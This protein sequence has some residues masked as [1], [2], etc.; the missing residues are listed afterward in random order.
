MP[1]GTPRKADQQ[2]GQRVAPYTPALDALELRSLRRPPRRDR[3]RD[4]R[5]RKGPVPRDTRPPAQRRRAVKRWHG[6]ARRWTV[7][8]E[9]PRRNRGMVRLALAG[10]SMRRIAGFGGA[11]G[12]SQVHRIVRQTCTYSGGRWKVSHASVYSMQTRGHRTVQPTVG[13]AWRG[14]WPAV[15][16][17]GATAKAGPKSPKVGTGLH[18]VE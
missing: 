2:A 4:G 14:D 12:K 1:K 9:I 16:R 6:N 10:W 5:F 18:G 17:G 3:L 11:L 13:T 7:M 15:E 8:V